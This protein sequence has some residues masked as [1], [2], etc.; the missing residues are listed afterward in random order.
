MNFSEY[1]KKIYPHLSG[2]SNQGWFI[3]ELFHAAGSTFFARHPEYGTDAYH[4]KVYN[5]NKL[6]NKKMKASFPKP[7]LRGTLAAFFNHR[8]GTESLSKMMAGFEISTDVVLNKERFVE[9]LCIQFESIVSEVS[10]SVVDIVSAT[11]LELVSGIEIEIK[12]MPLF[13]GDDYTIVGNK[14]IQRIDIGFY[15]TFTY[16][17]AIKNN[18]TVTWENRCFELANQ[19]EVK[20]EAKTSKVDIPITKPDEEVSITV[21]FD[22]RGDERGLNEAIWQITDNTGQLCFPNKDGLRLIIN[23]YNDLGEATPKG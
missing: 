15:K 7:I 23:V 19:H 22:S 3:G 6:L 16:T 18:G 9:A 20:P 21:T 13:D 2:L 11:Y 10:D 1:A 12:P 17:W 8:I 4:V 5:G 14:P